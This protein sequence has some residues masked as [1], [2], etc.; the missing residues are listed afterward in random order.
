MQFYRSKSGKQEDTSSNEIKTFDELQYDDKSQQKLTLSQHAI[1]D[2]TTPNSSNQ[3]IPEQLDQDGQESAD[4]YNMSNIDGTYDVSSN[5]RHRANPNDNNIYSHTAD[6]IYDSGSH[7][8]LPD[9][10]EETYDHL[11]GQQTEDEY[12]T[13]ART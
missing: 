9:R 11:F 3:N 6:N 13:T 2:K 4:L 7:H 1:Q 12:D 8:K 5:D 10:N